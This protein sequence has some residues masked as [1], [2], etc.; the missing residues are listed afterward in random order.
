MSD[1]EPVVGFIGLGIMGSAMA[2]NLL[3]AGPLLVWNR[4]PE[5]RDRLATA[6]ASVAATS[7]EVFERCSVV[8]LMLT[9]DRATDAVLPLDDPG[10]LHDR[11]VVQMSTLS[12]EY[13]QRSAERVRAAGG[14]YV[15]APVSGSRQPAIDATLVAMVA[16]EDEDLNRIAPLLDSMCAS[17]LRCGRVPNGLRMKLAVNTFLITMVTGLAEAFHFAEQHR[18]DPLQ[19]EAALAAGPMA[20]AVSRAKAAKI[21]HQDWSV[22][23]A[24]PDVLKNSRLIVDEARRHHVASPLMDVCAD[25]FAQTEALGHDHEDMAAVITA[26][27]DRTERQ[28]RP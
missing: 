17:V 20:S 9:D 4:S 1:A 2:A 18:L 19:L 8:F 15:E 7:R 27:R 3:A 11:I 5:A 14:R 6:G 23:A 13:S 10:A 25:L 16:G 21:V 28:G 26:V 12:P 22:H 24:V